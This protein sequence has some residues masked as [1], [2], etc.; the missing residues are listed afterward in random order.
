MIDPV[1]EYQ[2][3]MTDEEK[4]VERG[5]VLLRV[6]HHGWIFFVEARECQGGA[7]TG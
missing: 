4:E 2:H 7:A 1:D 5:K 3:P 6:T